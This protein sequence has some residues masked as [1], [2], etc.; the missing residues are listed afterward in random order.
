MWRTGDGRG[1]DWTYRREK[2]CDASAVC[3]HCVPFHIVPLRGSSA[4]CAGLQPFEWDVR[5]VY[6]LQIVVDATGILKVQHVNQ[7]CQDW[8]KC[9]HTPLKWDVLLALASPRTFLR[10]VWKRSGKK[11]TERCQHPLPPRDGKGVKT[12]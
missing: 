3:A 12:L 8:E 10:L 9:P 1:A 4:V 7:L 11:W 5:K 2:S 6:L